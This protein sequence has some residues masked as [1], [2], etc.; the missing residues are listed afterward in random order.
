M[1]AVDLEVAV[2]VLY[3]LI[4]LKHRRLYIFVFGNYIGY[5]I[6]SNDN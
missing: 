6:T 5:T 3:Q 2:C 1:E 4:I